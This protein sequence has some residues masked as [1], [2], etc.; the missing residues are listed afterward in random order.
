MAHPSE[1]EG[2]SDSRTHARLWRARPTA[3]MRAPLPHVLGMLL[4]AARPAEGAAP[5][6]SST[7]E[8][9]ETPQAL[10]GL[11][12]LPVHD[13]DPACGMSGRRWFMGADDVT[14]CKPVANTKWLRD[15]CLWQRM[16]PNGARIGF[17]HVGK[18][19]GNSVSHYLHRPT[20]NASLGHDGPTLHIWDMHLLAQ[21]L[22]VRDG[23]LVAG[24]L[25]YGDWDLLII[26]T[27][28]PIERTISAF[29]FA[30][31][32]PYTYT[33]PLLDTMNKECFA[34][35]PGALDAFALEL[36][37][38]TVCGKIAR[39]CLHEA[40]GSML[41]SGTHHRE[42]VHTEPYQTQCGHINMGFEHYLGHEHF[43]QMS[44]LERIR[45]QQS[46]AFLVRAQSMNQDIDAMW[47]WLCVP[48]ENRNR[49]QIDNVEG[50]EKRRYHDK[51][52][53][54]EGRLNLK[55]HLS[56]EYQMLEALE[57][58]ADNG[59]DRAMAPRV[60]RVEEYR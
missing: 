34:H 28:D 54:P 50:H 45:T 14:T 6:R 15:D 19:G 39:R 8:L 25:A 26:S 52:L 31:D 53:S 2:P 17:V 13:S 9:Q 27:R 48:P 38:D 37:K 56:T 33:Y 35:V 55:G 22:K 32:M 29:N 11:E 59:R 40:H 16:F 42:G 24:G 3:A 18:T 4:L 30:L 21:T 20:V 41:P 10:Q 51:Y 60:E 36:D 23:A 12:A 43:G 46:R 44:L 1:A 57:Q 5:P 58:L 49:T 47:D 7:L